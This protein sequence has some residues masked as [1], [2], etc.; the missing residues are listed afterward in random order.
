MVEVLI[1]DIGSNA[2]NLFAQEYPRRPFSQLVPILSSLL[3]TSPPKE[4]WGISGRRHQQCI[5]GTISDCSHSHRSTGHC[6][7]EDKDM[8]SKRQWKLSYSPVQHGYWL[9]SYLLRVIWI[10]G[11]ASPQLFL[12][13]CKRVL[14]YHQMHHSDNTEHHQHLIQWDGA[15]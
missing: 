8:Q 11:S 6:W 2:L 10:Q 9:L 14:W 13:N 3:L 12:F 7:F 4:Q 5:S 1:E 15:Q